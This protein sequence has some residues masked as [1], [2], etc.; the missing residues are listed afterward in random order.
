M[1]TEIELAWAAG[2][3]DGEGCI[4]CR[5]DHGKLKHQFQL[6]ISI[7]NTSLRSLERFKGIVQHGPI[8]VRRT[9]IGNF[10]PYKP[11][12]Q[13]RSVSKQAHEVL[14]LLFPYLVTKRQEAEL[15]ISARKYLIGNRGGSP[16]RE[17]LQ[18]IAFEIRDL[19][20]RKEGEVLQ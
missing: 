20:G 5:I 12:W 17:I 4:H 11:N 13:W 6:I 14:V 1:A 3:F 2:F 7:S 8:Y 10:G 16:H 15:A 18:G 9:Y 19:K